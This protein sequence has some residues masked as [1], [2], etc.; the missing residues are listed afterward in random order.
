M[1]K[2]S[3]II[4]LFAVLALV[5]SCNKSQ[6]SGGNTY[7]FGGNLILSADDSFVN[8]KANLTLSLSE[9]LASD[10]TV[11]LAVNENGESAIKASAL[12]FQSVVTIAS[13][14][15]SESV[16]VTLVTEPNG[17][18]K[19]YF[20]IAA[21]TGAVAERSGATISFNPSSSDP[22]PDPEQGSMTLQTN[23]KVSVTGQ[24]LE[25]EEY[26]GYTYYYIAANLTAPGSTYIYTDC[27]VDDAEFKEYGG[28]SIEEW[29]A[30]LESELLKAI[31]AGTKIDDMLYTAGD[32]YLNYYGKGDTYVYVLDFDAKGKLTGK[33]AKIAVTMPDLE[34]EEGSEYSDVISVSGTG[35]A[36][37]YFDI[38][39]KG[40]ITDAN[41]QESMLELAAMCDEEYQYY[42][43]A[44]GDVERTDFMLDSEYNYFEYDALELGKYDVLIVGMSADGNLTGEY[45]ISTI[46]VDGHELPD[47]YWEYG[48]SAKA[49][50]K[51]LRRKAQL[52]DFTPQITGPVT[53]KQAWVASYDG[54]T[55]AFDWGSLLVKKSRFGRVTR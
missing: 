42:M 17:P 38:Y 30:S 46:E 21:V 11:T 39:D 31:A 10:V 50:R 23:W 53:R 14:K 2:T 34:G 5:C 19:A 13:G 44:W 27:F 43:E 36:L 49:N 51:A 52:R 33:Y 48:Y 24:E 47:N 9:A 35:D 3:L 15:T 7:S 29:A 32:I 40:S 12:E 25:S 41:L 1:K 37:F 4:V 6:T 18:A 45:N 54:R 55:E 26:D 22:D 8:G 28:D 20:V 16:P